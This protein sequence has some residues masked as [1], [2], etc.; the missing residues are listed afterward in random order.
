MVDGLRTSADRRDDGL[1]HPLRRPNEHAHQQ[2]RRRGPRPRRPRADLRIRSTR[3]W[4]RSSGAT[5]SSPTARARSPSGPS[6]LSC[7]S[8]ARRRRSSASRSSARCSTRPLGR[9]RAVLEVVPG[10]RRGAERP[11][12]RVRGRRPRRGPPLPDRGRLRPRQARRGLRLLAV[13]RGPR[14]RAAAEPDAAAHAPAA[15]GRRA[16]AAPGDR[17]RA[18]AL[19]GL[20]HGRHARRLPPDR[21]HAVDR[22]RSSPPARPPAPSRTPTSRSA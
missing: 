9:R 14:L 7:C 15:P 2:W 6:R 5:S 1:T 11:G 22:R 18:A 13:P 17:G 16:R 8:A 20:A 21:A 19:G 4:S 12:P 10:E 3:C